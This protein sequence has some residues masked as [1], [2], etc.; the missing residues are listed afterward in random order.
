MSLI[1]KPVNKERY[2]K[3]IKPLLRSPYNLLPFAVWKRTANGKGM[4]MLFKDGEF[5]KG[6]SKAQLKKVAARERKSAS[7]PKLSVRFVPAKI[8]M[9]NGRT[10]SGMARRNPKTGRVQLRIT[11]V[12]ARKINPELREYRVVFFNKKAAKNIVV[13]VYA[14]TAG[15]A[16]K[17]ARKNKKDHVPG[18]YRNWH[19]LSVQ[20]SAGER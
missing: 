2:E 11:K 8:R 16:S 17:L 13:P 14:T 7:N 12:V 4:Y 3:Q 10:V 6:G 20:R 15:N 5:I 18:D 1:I 9:K 19:V